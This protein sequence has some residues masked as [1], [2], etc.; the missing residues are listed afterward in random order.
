[1]RV[2]F[3][4]VDP[5]T[6]R[7]VVERPPHDRID[8]SLE[9]RS[10]LIH[11]LAH[12]AVETALGTDAG[13]YGHLAAGRSLEELREPLADAEAQQ[14]L[15]AIERQVAMLQSAFRR[16]GAGAAEGADTLRRLE[17]AWRK[18]RQ[19]EALTVTWPDPAPAVVPAPR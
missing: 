11:D 19:G 6:H 9:T 15:M 5:K 14:A 8:V 4:R 2:W 1:M 12:Y 18:A 16:G 7:L 3:T 10:L 13:F 17:G